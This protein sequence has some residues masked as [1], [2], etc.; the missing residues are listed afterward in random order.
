MFHV[1]HRGL[2]YTGGMEFLSTDFAAGFWECMT[3]L[4]PLF[5]AA[6]LLWLVMTLITDVLR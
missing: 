2:C 4:V 5:A 3:A 1:K 6:I